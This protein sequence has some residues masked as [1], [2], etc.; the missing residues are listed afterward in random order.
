MSGSNLFLEILQV[1]AFLVAVWFSGR[2]CRAIGVSPILGEILAGVVMGPH[3]LDVV[4]YEDHAGGHSAFPSVFVL[5]GNVSHR[6]L[7]RAQ[8]L[9]GYSLCVL[10][11]ACR[12][13][14]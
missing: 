11:G 6:V 12:F 8:R 1:V 10:S 4:P 13:V 5:A 2:V 9:H 7:S 14:R 3:V